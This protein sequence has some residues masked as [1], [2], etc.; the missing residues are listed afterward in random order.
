MTSPFEAASG[1]RARPSRRTPLLMSATERWTQSCPRTRRRPLAPPK[2]V[3][4]VE[5]CSTIARTRVSLSARSTPWPAPSTVS[6]LAPGISP[7][8]T[9][10]CSSGNSGSAVPW[11]TRVGTAIED[12]GA[13]DVAADELPGSGLVEAALAA[14]E[15]LRIADD[16]VDDRVSI[17]PVHLRGRQ[18][19]FKALGRSRKRPLAGRGGRRADENKREHALRKGEGEQLREGPARRDSDH[20]R[21]R[22]PVGVEHANRV[23][24]EVGPRV[25]GSSRLIGDRAAR[26]A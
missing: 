24:N 9:C 22:D 10:P 3:A 5:V 23:G 26:V 25:L 4:R 12:T 8:S 1:S 6:S 21:G 20:V 17:G 14:G 18:E 7:A 11:I 15:H 2:I 19:P 16:V 13:L